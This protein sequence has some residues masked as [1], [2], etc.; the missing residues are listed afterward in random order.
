M[1]ETRTL[2]YEI[3][4]AHLHIFD[5]FSYAV[6]TEMKNRGYTVRER[7]V[8]RKEPV[9]DMSRRFAQKRFEALALKAMVH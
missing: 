8:A 7:L 1:K 3:S 6:A 5:T 4:S 9:S 2:I